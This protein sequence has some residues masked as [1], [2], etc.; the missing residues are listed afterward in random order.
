LLKVVTVNSPSGRT[1][2]ILVREVDGEILLLDTESD[3]IHQLNSMASLIWRNLK[4][5]ASAS[6]I[7]RRLAEQFDVDENIAFADVEDILG[8]LRALKVIEVTS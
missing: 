2:G 3:Q 5:G 6:E 8:K 7:A 4:E 1:S